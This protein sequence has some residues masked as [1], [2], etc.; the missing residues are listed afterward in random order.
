M[1]PDEGEPDSARTRAR[2]WEHE[3]RAESIGRSYVAARRAIELIR[4]YR[5]EPASTGRRERECL[6]E[7]ARL[8]AAI[9][10]LRATDRIADGDSM[11]GLRK[12]DGA[13]GSEEVPASNRRTG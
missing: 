13:P 4:V 9:A 10:L 12:V 6:A 2:L 5:R 11:P 1:E 3:E 7:V 8:R